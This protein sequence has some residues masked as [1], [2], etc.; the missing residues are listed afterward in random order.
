MACCVPPQS[1]PESGL[2]HQEAGRF[3]SALEVAGGLTLAS[4]LGVSVVVQVQVWRAVRSEGEDGEHDDFKVRTE[5]RRMESMKKAVEEQETIIAK[6]REAHE[7]LD[8]EKRDVRAMHRHEEDG[9]DP[10]A[11]KGT[12]RAT[13][14]NPLQEDTTE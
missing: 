3:K 11:A 8:K 9:E 10:P 5:M 2:S 6:L 12:E 13:S 1:N 7:L 14:E 4:A